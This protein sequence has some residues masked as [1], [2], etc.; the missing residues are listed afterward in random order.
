MNIHKFHC[1]YT[2][3]IICFGLSLLMETNAICV[4]IGWFSAPI[5]SHYYLVFIHV[6]VSVTSQSLMISTVKM[7]KNQCGG[8]GL[9]SFVRFLVDDC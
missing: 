1:G 6:A 3:C 8:R 7:L 5:T 4:A 9:K 2:F